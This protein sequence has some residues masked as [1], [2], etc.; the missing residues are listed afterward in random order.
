MEKYL[1]FNVSQFLIDSRDWEGRSAELA[2]YVSSTDDE[3]KTDEAY[4]ELAWI[5]YFQCL[6]ASARAV[7]SDKQND[8]IDT[9]FLNPETRDRPAEILAQK[10]Q[11]TLRHVYSMRADALE[12]L[13]KLITEMI[14]GASHE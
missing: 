1:E 10:Y 14:E 7:L 3:T 4:T 9:F 8:V 2:E 12:N 6:L 11:V 5:D 13:R